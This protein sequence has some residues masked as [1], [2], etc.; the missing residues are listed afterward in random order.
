MRALNMSFSDVATELDYPRYKND[1]E[2]PL[3]LL[4]HLPLPIY[5]TTSYHD[6][7]QRALQ[8]AKKRPHTQI[9]LWSDETITL[10]PEHNIPDDFVPTVD[11]PLV[12]H[13]HGL[14]RYPESLVLSEDDYMKFLVKIS[15]DTDHNDQVIPLPL[16]A[17]LAESSL[18]LLGYRL[19]DWDFRVFFQGLIEAKHDSLRRFSL[20]I[21]ID[22]AERKGISQGQEIEKAK[23]YLKAYFNKSKSQFYV[24]WDSPDG[25]VKKLATSWNTWRETV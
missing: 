18:L 15:Q 22:P 25:F 7:M 9:C 24:N 11:E 14:E 19:E 21:Q 13:L 6:F 8:E 20:A 4:A 1:H 5:I 2:D 3:Q 12:Y 10:D 17:K 23:K 16:R